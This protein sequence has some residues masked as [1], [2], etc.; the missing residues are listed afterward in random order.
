M[1]G[2]ASVGQLVAVIQSRFRERAQAPAAGAARRAA[3]AAPRSL[4]DQVELQV[5]RIDPGDPQRGR[6]AFR[7]FLESVLLQE[8]GGHLNLDPGF[9]QMVD[10]VQRV[11]EQDPRCAP[12]VRDA[13]SHLLAAKPADTST[14]KT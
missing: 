7:V 2:I 5:A 1:N 10:D 4:G 14:R 6:K 8:L 3:R 12:L 11:L 9:H 13:I